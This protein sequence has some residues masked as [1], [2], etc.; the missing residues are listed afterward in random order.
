MTYSF[1]DSCCNARSVVSATLPYRCQADT[2]WEVWA[3]RQGQ[4]GWIR[5]SIH[6]TAEAASADCSNYRLEWCNHYDRVEVV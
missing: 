1:G 6:A 4:C 5:L 2:S 3:H